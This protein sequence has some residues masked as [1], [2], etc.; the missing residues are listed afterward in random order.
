MESIQVKNLL[1]KHYHSR[2]CK[3]VSGMNGFPWYFLSDDVSYSTQGYE[4]GDVRLL[5]IPDKEQTV[6]FTH[7]LLDQN[8]VES[9]WLPQFQPLLDSVEDQFD[10][11]IDWLRVRLSLLLN[12][13][14]TGHNAPHTDSEQDHYAALYYFHE[15]NA[16]TVFFNQMDEESR[17][18]IEQRWMFAMTNKEWTV[19]DRVYPEPNMLHIFNG[20]QFHASSTPTGKEKYRIT[21]NLNWTTPRD[22]F[23]PDRNP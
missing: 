18:T 8:N 23:N 17:G 14:K 9:P 21:L 16:P 11:Q 3:L 7:V 6:G 1:G 15:S 13:G 4:F 10:Y 2:L 19:A 20:H 5:E 12:N 22:L